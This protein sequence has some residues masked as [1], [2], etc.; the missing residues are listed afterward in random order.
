MRLLIALALAAILFPSTASADDYYDY[1][2]SRDHFE[3]TLGFMMGQRAYDDLAF[4]HAG[5]PSDLLGGKLPGV[6]TSGASLD[7]VLVYGLH[8]D[9]RAV[10][11]YVRMTL[12][13]D[14]PFPDPSA[15]VTTRTYTIGGVDREVTVLDVAPYELRFGLGG[16]IPFDVIVPFIDLIGAYHWVDMEVASG[17]DTMRYEATRFGFSVRGGARV[18]LEE[19]AF[20]EFAGEAGIVG[21]TIWSATLAVGFATD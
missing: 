8:W 3:I 19:P 13:F 7:D 6:V 5:G 11:S 1:D 10:V 16:E 14:L 18:Y 21:D 15:Y 20:L 2:E 12:G 9:I 4:I 17:A